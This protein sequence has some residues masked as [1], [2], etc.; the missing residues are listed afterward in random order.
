MS[1]KKSVIFLFLISMIVIGGCAVSAS[2]STSESKEKQVTIGS[3]LESPEKFV[4]QNVTFSG[5]ITS[6]CGSGCWFIL[7]DDSGEMYVTLRAN[8]FVIPPSMGKKAT[9]TGLVEK[10][11]DVLVTGSRVAVGDKTYP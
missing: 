7:S 1:A 2:N 6:Q 5:I 3:I 8:N 10:K 9:V 4:G 11:D